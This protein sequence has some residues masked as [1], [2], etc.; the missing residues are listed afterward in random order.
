MQP[1]G[2][3]CL[4]LVAPGS[5]AAAKLRSHTREERGGGAAETT[6]T[7]AWIHPFTHVTK[8]HTDTPTLFLLSWSSL[9]YNYNI[10]QCFDTI[11]PVYRLN[12]NVL[13]CGHVLYMHVTYIEDGKHCKGGK[14]FKVFL[15]G[16]FRFAIPGILLRDDELQDEFGCLTRPLHHHRV[17]TVIEQVHPAPRQ[18]LCNDCSSRYIHHLK[19]MG[20]LGLVLKQRLPSI[21][22]CIYTYLYMIFWVTV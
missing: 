15:S 12:G 22:I 2:H 3:W 11:N 19:A 7:S 1:D 8:W 10:R 17:A 14:C 13:K 16:R 9:H 4:L 5:C 20:I 6:S 18:H 21:H